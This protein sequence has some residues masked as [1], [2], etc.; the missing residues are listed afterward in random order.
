MFTAVP[1][2]RST[3]IQAAPSVVRDDDLIREAIQHYFVASD[4][5]SSTEL[6]RAFHPGAMMFWA[7]SEGTLNS[8]S[9]PQWWELL[10]RASTPLP[11][12]RREIQ[13][14][15]IAGDTAVASLLSRY[16][17]HQFQD[18]VLL[19]RTA[20]RWQIIAK[21]FERVEGVATRREATAVENSRAAILDVLAES[22]RATD[23]HDTDLLSKSYHPRATVFQVIE[24]QLVTVAL[25]EWQARFRDKR[26]AGERNT[27][28]RSVTKL[29]SSGPAAVVELLH[30]NGSF[31][32]T[33]Y[34][35]LV[36]VAG[37]WQIMA[38]TFA[39]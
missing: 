11:A 3:P 1:V 9:Q 35:L 14:I 12:I 24:N 4:T 33:E 5:G 36:E 19:A 21:V 30:D 13:W 20:G 34:A 27:A 26:A 23:T 15:D 6:R 39:Q 8:R 22:F 17:H 29:E 25:P 18:Y 31:P 28:A 2:D 7:S 10:D 37:A 38:L 32:R 16:S